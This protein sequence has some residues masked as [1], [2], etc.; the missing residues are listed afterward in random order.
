MAMQPPP[1]P[2]IG[3]TEEIIKMRIGFIFLAKIWCTSK[4]MIRCHNL[5]IP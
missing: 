2:S 1:E 5:I 3:I 4:P